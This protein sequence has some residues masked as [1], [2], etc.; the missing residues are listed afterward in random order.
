MSGL[1]NFYCFDCD[2]SYCTELKDKKIVKNEYGSFEG[3]KCPLCGGDA[4]IM[5]VP[6][7]GTSNGR[8]GSVSFREQ[9]PYLEGK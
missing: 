2:K 7:S 1:Y 8:F 3:M 9:F 4:K 6:A 5:G